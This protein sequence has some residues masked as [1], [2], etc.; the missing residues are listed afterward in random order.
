[1][2]WAFLAMNI[3]KTR[4]NNKMEG[5]VLKNSWILYIER[6]IAMKLGS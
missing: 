6:E 4:L 2:E 3:V 1:M 5:N